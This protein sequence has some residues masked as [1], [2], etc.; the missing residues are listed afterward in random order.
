MMQ[1]LMARL[2]ARE[3]KTAGDLSLT[4]ALACIDA[5]FGRE[6]S[7]KLSDPSAIVSYFT[8]SEWAYSMYHSEEDCI[9]LA[10]NED[11]AFKPEG[12]YVHPRYVAQQIQSL[13][14]QTVLE[15]GC[16]KG[17]NSRFLAEQFPSVKF[18]GLDI[19]PLHIDIARNKSKSIK[20][21]S[22]QTGDFNRLSY[23]SDSVDIVF[24]FETLCYAKEPSIIFK[25]FYRVL[26]PGGQLIVFDAF[27]TASPS[28]WSEDMQAAVKLTELSM[29][30]E[31][32]FAQMKQWLDDAQSAGFQ[33]SV[34]KDLTTAVRPGLLRLQGLSQRFFRLPLR[35][36]LLGWISPPYLVRN[37]IAG[38]LMPYVFLPHDSPVSYRQIALSKPTS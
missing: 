6:R 35:A 10:I 2:S 3:T 16:G 15:V 13:Q 12:Y 33:I 27:S 31:H 14:A 30:V 24:A 22:F 19:T 28:S 11:G 29:V 34:D 20:N 17:F 32:G 26:R 23:P 38:L 4:Q 7:L 18:L 9:H 8:Q 36:R 5:V 21:L 25:E 1:R 37:A